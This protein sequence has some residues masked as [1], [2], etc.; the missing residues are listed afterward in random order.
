MA[1]RRGVHHPRGLDMQFQAVDINRE[2]NPS[3][4]ATESESDAADLSGDESSG[5][6]RGQR[7]VRMGGF[8]LTPYAETE[9]EWNSAGYHRRNL[10]RWG[11]NALN[12]GAHLPDP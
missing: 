4:S 9:E 5:D 8:S 1:R 7:P 11:K 6:E 12:A 10:R 3:A 2:F